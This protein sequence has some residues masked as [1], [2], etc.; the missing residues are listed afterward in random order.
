MNIENEFENDV[1]DLSKGKFKGKIRVPT[2]EYAFIEVL[3][4]GTAEEIVE[5]HNTLT[6]AYKGGSGL[7]EKEMDAIIQKMI[8]GATVEGG[9][10]LY[11]KMSPQQQK[12]T[13]R[14]K[15][16]MKRLTYQA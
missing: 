10:E 13:Q 12:E 2:A 3:V 14:I 16:A 15:R 4:R 8:S 5:A 6:E 11:S 7:S 9:T 1:S